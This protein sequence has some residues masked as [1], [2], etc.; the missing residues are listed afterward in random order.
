MPDQG[1]AFEIDKQTLKD[2]D[3]FDHGSPGL[4]FAA[5]C[6]DQEQPFPHI[7]TYRRDR[8]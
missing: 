4:V 5:F 6:R 8:G 1:I 3:L 2:I 7:H